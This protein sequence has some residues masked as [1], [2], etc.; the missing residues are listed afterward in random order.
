MAAVNSPRKR[1]STIVRHEWVVHRTEGHP[2][3]I[4][5]L[6]DAVFVATQELKELGVDTA[7]HD[8][9]R[10]RPDDDDIVIFAEVKAS[11]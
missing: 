8:V 1:T 3:A 2:I 9:L 11:S 5:D 6:N 10:L 7:A 4:G